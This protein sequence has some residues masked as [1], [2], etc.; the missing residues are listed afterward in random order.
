MFNITVFFI[1]MLI[2]WLTLVSLPTRDFVAPDFVFTSSMLICSF[3]YILLGEYWG[4]DISNDTFQIMLLGS[5]LF[6][7][8]SYIIRSNIIFKQKSRCITDI[9][10]RESY[11]NA[12]ILKCIIFFSIFLMICSFVKIDEVGGVSVY[13]DLRNHGLLQ[14]QFWTNQLSKLL[15]ASAL[16]L[17]Y[18]VLYYKVHKWNLKNSNSVMA[19]SIISMMA[20]FFYSMGRMVI[21]EF[22][23]SIIIMHI[24]LLYS[25]SRPVPLKKS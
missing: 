2:I 19:T 6:I 7:I 22:F 1:I 10:F 16:V 3:F 8:C 4:S 23:L 13:R 11:V 15:S 25:I 20:C 18:I 5:C 12:R 17:A 14:G 21:I 24:L 9:A